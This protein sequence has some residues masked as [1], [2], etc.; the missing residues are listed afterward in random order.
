MRAAV[1]LS[2][3]LAI[4]FL[5][6]I[7]LVQLTLDHYSACYYAPLDQ[8]YDPLSTTIHSLNS[9]L[10]AVADLHW[11]KLVVLNSLGWCFMYHV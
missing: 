6:V 7:L 11:Q 4:L 5:L 2:L 8:S 3:R 10:M 1:I 9:A